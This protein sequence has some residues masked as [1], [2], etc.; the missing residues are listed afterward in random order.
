MRSLQ[1][2]EKPNKL[3]DDLNLTQFGSDLLRVQSVRH[4]A[5]I[6]GDELP[7]GTVHVQQEYA[8]NVPLTLGDAKTMSASEDVES[9]DENGINHLT[10]SVSSR[11]LGLTAVSRFV[12]ILEPDT[13]SQKKTENRRGRD[14][15]GSTQK[16]STKEGYV[17]SGTR[18]IT[19]ADIQAYG[20]YSGSTG[21]IHTS[22]DFARGLG[23]QD[24][25][26]QGM[27]TLGVAVSAVAD[28]EPWS[29][30]G[31]ATSLRA[32]FKKP[33]YANQ[34]FDIYISV[35]E[36]RITVHDRAAPER[37]AVEIDLGVQ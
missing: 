16:G 4:W 9:K 37:S 22:R 6:L 28:S 15:S 33:L 14:P 2:L 21:L 19:A 3:V 10:I 7:A 26:I 24:A 32:R 1:I 23:Y 13:G 18:T 34:P 25:L 8:F 11:D 17:L 30:L 20:D 31:S 36:Q 29:R 35:R 12:R 27:L 5:A